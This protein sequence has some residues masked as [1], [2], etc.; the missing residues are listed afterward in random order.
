MHVVY[1]LKE[2]ADEPEV[3]YVGICYLPPSSTIERAMHHRLLGHIRGTSRGANQPS[4]EWIRSLGEAPAIVALGLT[5]DERQIERFWIRA[6]L[7]D[8]HRLTNQQHSG[9]GFRRTGT[10]G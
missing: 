7:R 6:L 4:A 8:G 1:A 9:N 3:R 5:N 10:E 2:T